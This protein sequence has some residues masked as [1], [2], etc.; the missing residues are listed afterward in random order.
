MAIENA[1]NSVDKD[2][3][4]PKKNMLGYNKDDVDK[5]I[6]YSKIEKEMNLYGQVQGLMNHFTIN[7]LKEIN[8]CLNSC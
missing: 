1:N 6:D 2:I 8:K 5:M 7:N 3:L 4:N